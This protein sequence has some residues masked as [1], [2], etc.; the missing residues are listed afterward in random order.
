MVFRFYNYL[1]PKEKQ[2][3]LLLREKKILL[4]IE[5]EPSIRFALRQIKDFSFPLQEG[6]RLFWRFNSISEQEARELI[7]K[8]KPKEIKK[9]VRE[10]RRLVT[11]EKPEKRKEK[12]EEKIEKRKEKIEEKQLIKLKKV[13]E[14]KIK[15]KSW[16]VLSVLDFLKHQDIEVLEEIDWKK[17]EYES[18]VR[19]NSDLGKI[20][21]FCLAKDKKSITEN[22]LTL[23]L[24][25]SRDLK[26]PALI[27]SKA[28]LNKKA[29]QYL[30][31][32][33]NLIKFLR[34]Q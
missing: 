20:E 5:Q 1:P 27:I 10:E 22:D 9:I 24:N 14:K 31:E 17:R 2:A 29:E 15:E 25:K 32:W 6:E 4:D 19:I 16:F 21:F 8:I 33:K 28:G 12:R 11:I 23:V 34:I 18:R 13:K 7:S 3:F 26:L 30:Q